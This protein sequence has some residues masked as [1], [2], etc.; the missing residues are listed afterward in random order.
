MSK[1]F[2]AKEVKK[3]FNDKKYPYPKNVAM[4]CAWI[5]GNF[6]GYNLKVYDVSKKSSLAD[7]YVIGSATNPTQAQTMAEEI[8]FQIKQL[9]QSVRSFEGRNGSDWLLLDV[10]NVMIHIL[11]ESSRGLFDLDSLWSD[12]PTLEIPADYYHSLESEESKQ[13]KST[14]SSSTDNTDEGFF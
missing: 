5:I 8:N 3:I 7:F 9:G 12:Y 1:E 14:K 10:G 4:V 11:L 6:K 13:P 2:I